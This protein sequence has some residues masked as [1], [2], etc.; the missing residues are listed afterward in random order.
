MCTRPIDCNILIYAAWPLDDMILP[1]GVLVRPNNI[2]PNL[3]CFPNALNCGLKIRNE[4]W[5]A[6]ALE[7]RSRNRRRSRHDDKSQ[8]EPSGSP[9]GNSPHHAALS[10]SMDPH[11]HLLQLR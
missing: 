3:C 9:Q 10:V 8:T 1:L 5:I 4:Y 2:G 6:Y 7:C 11:E